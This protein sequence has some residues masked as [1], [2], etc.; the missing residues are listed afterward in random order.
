MG[1]L[2]GKIIGGIATGAFAIGGAVTVSQ[3]DTQTDEIN[4]Q[5]DSMN[6]LAEK[7]GTEYYC[8]S[9]DECA[10]INGTADE[11]ETLNAEN[12]DLLEEYNTLVDKYNIE[13]ANGNGIDKS[14]EQKCLDLNNNAAKMVDEISEQLEKLDTFIAD[15]V[16]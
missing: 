8:Y 12:D 11:Y 16:E 6:I 4:K 10:V 15:I 1:K 9:T 2:V 14:E 13:C 7:I 3:L 5:V